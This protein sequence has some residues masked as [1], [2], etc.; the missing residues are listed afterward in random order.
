[1]PLSM[2]SISPPSAP[3]SLPPS[4]LWHSSLLE[5]T[6]SKYLVTLTLNRPSKLNAFTA[7]LLDGL[8][9]C[10]SKLLSLPPEELAAVVLTGAGRAFCA[11]ADLSDPPDPRVHSSLRPADLRRNPV[12]L[13]SQLRV[14]VVGAL[15][16][17]AFTGGLE[18]ALACDVLVAGPALVMRDTHCRFGIAP[19]WGLSQ[20]LQRIVGRGRASY[21]SLAGQPVDAAT[22]L[23]WGLV[24]EV[25]G[26]GEGAA[27]ERAR[28]LCEDIGAQDAG[29]VAFY[30]RNL[31]GGGG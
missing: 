14:P 29:M 30:K 15:N 6:P 22:A 27:L 21:V 16:G 18:L 2:L 10:L 5:D 11:G 28:E 20:R 24:Q 19:C 7:P 13:M 1:M 3:P 8:C 4:V 31:E 23:R 25:V 12:H 17:P 9:A 26:G